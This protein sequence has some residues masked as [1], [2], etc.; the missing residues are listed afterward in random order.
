MN[1][2][3]VVDRPLTLGEIVDRSVTIAVRRWRT[4]GA[5]VLLEA[6]PVGFVA[7]VLRLDWLSIGIDL[8]LVPL[9]LC[10]AVFAAASPANLSVADVLRQA[11]PRYGRCVLAFIFGFVL[12]AMAGLPALLVGFLLG[13]LTATGGLGVAAVIVAGAAGVVILLALLPRFY[14]VGSLLF[15]IVALENTSAAE[16][17]S[18]A[19]RRVGNA[20]AA[21]AWRFGLTLFAVGLAPAIAVGAAADQLAEMTHLAA[22]RFADELVTDAISL[23]FS[24]VVAT[25]M[26]LEMRV[27]YEGSD[28]EAALRA[29]DAHH[30]NGAASSAAASS[31]GSE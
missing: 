7:T 30:E 5:L 1:F 14:L 29:R 19:F 8:V 25:V 3:P 15:P 20:G 24:S 12:V 31:A 17:W 23:G 18:I 11:V 21:R 22:F 10:A 9:L 28:I 4:L 26:S 6:L 2:G 27:R 13:A 16:A